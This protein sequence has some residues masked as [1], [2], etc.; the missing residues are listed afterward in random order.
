M[1]LR[2]LVGNLLLLLFEGVKLKV[3]QQAEQRAEQNDGTE[4][5]NFIQALQKHG[6]E[7]LGS[8][9]EFQSHRQALGK[10]DLDIHLFLHKG[11][12]TVLPKALHAGAAND[13]NANDFK[14]RN[15]I[16]KKAFNDRV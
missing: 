12:L 8:H 11:I 1:I 13:K 7:D 14:N 9:F 5:V 6:F 16:R 15:R 3:D 10:I 2:V 4:H